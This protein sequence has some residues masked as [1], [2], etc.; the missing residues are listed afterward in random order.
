MVENLVIELVAQNDHVLAITRK[1]PLF[2][3]SR[4]P[5]P[6]LA[7]EV[8]SCAMH[9]RGAL[10]LGVCSEEDGGAEDPLE[11]SN[12]TT[13]LR[14]A[15]LHP[16]GVQHLSRAVESDSGTLLHSQLLG[17][18]GEESGNEST[19]SIR[20]HPVDRRSS[21]AVSSNAAVDSDGDVHGR[22]VFWSAAQEAES[23]V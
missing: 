12:E 23:S 3:I 18:V 9:D 22:D 17:N 11:G 16:K 19:R 14:T 21:R 2:R 7:H 15:L 8:E 6:R 20:G 10:S 5:N 13:I 4:I 1:E